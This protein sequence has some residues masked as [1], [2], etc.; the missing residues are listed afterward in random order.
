M[1]SDD[2]YQ[3]FVR[4]DDTNDD[5]LQEW[6]VISKLELHYSEAN[7][8][9]PDTIYILEPVLSGF[10]LTSDD[11]PKTCAVLESEFEDIFQIV[12]D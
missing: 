7:G 2:D 5:N 4:A 8:N 11:A 9:E 1:S 6:R 12:E 10:E 3:T